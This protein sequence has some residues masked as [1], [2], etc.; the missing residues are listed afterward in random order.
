MESSNGS[1]RSHRK[2]REN[3]CPVLHH[4]EYALFLHSHHNTVNV[5]RYYTTNGGTIPDDKGDFFDIFVIHDG[6]LNG[7]IMSPVLWEGYVY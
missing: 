5:Q 6:N 4:M 1:R 7:F 3:V 2:A